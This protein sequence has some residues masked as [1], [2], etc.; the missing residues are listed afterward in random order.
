MRIEEEQKQLSEKILQEE[1]ERKKQQEEAEIRQKMA[2]DQQQKQIVEEKADDNDAKRA[3]MPDDIRQR[4]L[5]QQI[6][7]DLDATSNR[8]GKEQQ[9]I[10]VEDLLKEPQIGSIRASWAK[11]YS[12]ESD[13]GV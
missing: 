8:G 13:F 6:L 3:M 10:S 1:E 9:Y 12:E 5:E 7:A 4:E 11:V 2:K